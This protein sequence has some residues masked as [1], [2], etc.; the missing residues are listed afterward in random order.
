MNRKVPIGGANKKF[1]IDPH[2]ILNTLFPVPGQSVGQSN[3][4]IPRLDFL[5][6]WTAVMGILPTEQNPVVQQLCTQLETRLKFMFSHRPD[7]KTSKKKD[8]YVISDAELLHIMES[9]SYVNTNSIV[10][11]LAFLI[12]TP[13]KFDPLPLAEWFV[14]FCRTD[15]AMSAPDVVKNLAIFVKFRCLLENVGWDDSEL[16]FED[17]QKKILNINFEQ[18][19]LQPRDQI[20]GA[21][22]AIEVNGDIFAP[23]IIAASRIIQSQWISMLSLDETD[24]TSNECGFIFTYFSDII[25]EFGKD[26]QLALLSSLFDRAHLIS[27]GGAQPIIREQTFLALSHMVRCFFT[28]GAVINVTLLRRGLL[29]LQNFY[30]WQAPF[31]KV[32][33]SLII[34]IQN[35]LLAPGFAYR[36]FLQRE[37]NV[38][39]YKPTTTRN[40]T[41]ISTSYYSTHG[42]ISPYICPQNGYQT[43]KPIFYLYEN[44][45]RHAFSL[46]TVID[47]VEFDPEHSVNAV[48]EKLSNQNNNQSNLSHST[49]QDS[50]ECPLPPHQIMLLNVL[51]GIDID[52]PFTDA[53]LQLLKYLPYQELIPF[54]QKVVNFHLYLQTTNTVPTVAIRRKEYANLKIQLMQAA[55]EAQVYAND[56]HLGPALL[57]L[58]QCSDKHHRFAARSPNIDHVHLGIEPTF[59]LGDKPGF[60]AVGAYDKLLSL[61]ESFVPSNSPA[62]RR[63]SVAPKPAS[64]V[65]FNK[66]EDSESSVSRTGGGGGGGDEAISRVRN[67]SLYTS[68]ISDGPQSTFT[69]NDIIQQPIDGKRTIRIALLGTAKF[70]NRI[71]T[72][73]QK[74]VQNYPIIFDYISPIFMILPTGENWL[75]NYLARNDLWYFRHVYA[76]LCSPALIIPWIRDEDTSRLITQSSTIGQSYPCQY[77]RSCIIQYAQQ[78]VYHLP[79]TVYKVECST[80]PR[81]NDLAATIYFIQRLELGT[82]VA[83]EEWRT[84]N[85]NSPPMRSEEV[86]QQRGFQLSTLDMTIGYSK[87]DLSGVT[88]PEILEEGIQFQSLLLSNVPTKVTAITNLKTA[89]PEVEEK[90][91]K[92]KG[93]KDEKVPVITDVLLAGNQNDLTSTPD[94]VSNTLEAFISAP[95]VDKSKLRQGSLLSDP[96][97]HLRD[98]HCS[99]STPFKVRIDGVNYG[100]FKYIHVSPATTTLGQIAKFPIQTFL[101]IGGQQ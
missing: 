21:A 80:D 90:D 22:G 49:L 91:A 77:L 79:I 54:Y 27:Q 39:D 48:P 38:V 51:H 25:S 58:P 9:N 26:Y 7:E 98:I 5:G 47:P 76:P 101:P 78:A 73:Y 83:I 69:N 67:S 42:D 11:T 40:T 32:A 16:R 86:V 20:T 97:Q 14:K 61:F 94:P 88:Q 56:N 10:T 41:S 53:E 70:L 93:T 84:N 66:N 64:V 24:I 45:D 89:T 35:E 4:Q 99:S 33:E 19:K 8:K 2:T 18:I 81:A 31:G 55:A 75:A 68:K 59:G 6:F 43:N 37:C 15:Y 3:G 13:F 65:Q 60:P 52:S 87:C 71:V 36:H 1:G 82:Y 34:L 63:Q 96:K 92:K 72:A 74:I 28:Q 29:I 17:P 57:S 23:L 62:R 46:L 44:T 95:R 30:L 100:P 50:T 12:F 85:P